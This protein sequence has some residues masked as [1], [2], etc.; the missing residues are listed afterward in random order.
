MKKMSILFIIFLFSCGLA[1]S[2][3]Y[4]KNFEYEQPLEVN[5]GE[6][7]VT[8]EEG[9]KNDVYKWV[10][11][12]TRQELVYAGKDHNVLQIDYREYILNR[13]GAFIKDGFTQHLRYDL[14]ES[15]IIVYKNIKIKVLESSGSRIKYMVIR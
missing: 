11:S 9:K 4:T 1:V 12:G 2:E 13:D 7:L 3:F 10:V 14:A 5:V 15:D 8:I 6:N